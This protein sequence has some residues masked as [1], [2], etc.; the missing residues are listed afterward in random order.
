MFKKKELFMKKKVLCLFILCALSFVLLGALICALKFIDVG[1][2]GPND[3][4]IGLASINGAVKDI[5]GFNEAIYDLTELLGLISLATAAGFGV[6]GIVQL[7]KRKSLKRVDNDIYLLGCLYVA[8]AIFYLIF[9]VVVINHRP[10]ILEG[11]LEA[12][13]PSSHTL[14]SLCIMISAAHQLYIRLPSKLYNGIG[15]ATAVAIA[16]ATTALRLASGVHWF[17]DILGGILLSAALLFA[18]FAVFEL[19]KKK[20]D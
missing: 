10:V 19:I 1:T 5:F 18:Y 6:L 13:F 11:E 17:T 9:E 15:L 12:S 4:K 2:I 3:S 7:A 16:T 8:V 14:L 20:N